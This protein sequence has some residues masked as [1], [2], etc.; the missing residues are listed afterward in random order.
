VHIGIDDIVS[1]SGLSL[2]RVIDVH[3]LYFS[4]LTR[5]SSAQPY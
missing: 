1:D 4:H 3:V 2:D 5:S